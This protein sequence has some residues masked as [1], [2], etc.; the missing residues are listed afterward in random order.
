MA[1]RLHRF[2]GLAALPS[3]PPW[4]CIEGLRLQGDTLQVMMS[5]RLPDVLEHDSS[6][7]DL[8]LLQDPPEGHRP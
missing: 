5:F 7:A 8:L 3:V 6:L 2:P 4:V 1:K